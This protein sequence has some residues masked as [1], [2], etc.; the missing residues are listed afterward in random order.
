MGCSIGRSMAMGS[1]IGSSIGSSVGNR[2]GSSVS[3]RIGSNIGGSI[4]SNII[5]I[6]SGIDFIAEFRGKPLV[7]NKQKM[8]EKVNKDISF[9]QFFH[10]TRLHST[11]LFKIFFLLLTLPLLFCKKLVDREKIRHMR[12]VQYKFVQQNFGI[13][14]K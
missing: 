14:F 1:S 5:S 9:I 13:A 11:E 8:C 12:G 6:G 4:G 3:N 2:I 7:D 10:P